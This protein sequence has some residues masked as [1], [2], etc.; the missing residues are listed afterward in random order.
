MRLVACPSCHTQYDVSGVG[1]REVRCTCGTELPRQSPVAV[2]ARI[3]RCGSCGAA[4]D[5]DWTQCG[6]CRSPIVRDPRQLALICPE[7]FARNTEA[8]RFCTSCGVQFEPQPLPD[9][10]RALACPNDGARMQARSIGTAVVQSCERCHGLWIPGEQF[11]GLIAKLLKAVD[12]SRIAAAAPRR[13]AIPDGIVYRP[14]PECQDRMQRK[15]YG[16][17]SGIIIDWCGAHGTWLDADELEA[18]AAYLATGGATRSALPIE[19]VPQPKAMPRPAA[20]PT[21]DLFVL[22]KQ[23][24]DRLE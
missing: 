24:L 5:S 12:P 16:G 4:V 6:Y 20:S 2:D 13:R 23:A 19:L 1:A 3:E 10:T 7:C 22:F 21:D 11:E 9:E 17:R 18:I 8:S 15:N 14:C